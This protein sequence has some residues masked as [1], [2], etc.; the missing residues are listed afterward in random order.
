MTTVPSPGEAIKAA[1]ERQAAALAATR[2]VAD[3]IA[4]Q[5]AR[6]ATQKNPP[7]QTRG[8]GG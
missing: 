8:V 6:E 4:E 3:E 7:P 1:A 5:R 2:K